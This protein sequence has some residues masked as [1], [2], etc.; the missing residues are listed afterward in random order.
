V[1]IAAAIAII[2]SQRKASSGA[3]AP[4]GTVAGRPVKKAA[5]KAR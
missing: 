1:F 3:D 4:A 5:G 2:L